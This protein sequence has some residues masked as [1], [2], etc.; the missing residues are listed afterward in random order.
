[1]IKRIIEVESLPTLPKRTRVA[2]YARVSSGKDTMLNSLST[3]INHYKKYITDNQSWIFAGVYAD[4][5][6]TGTK[7]DRDEFQ[8]LIA[9][10]SAGK[11]D[12]V[13][14]KSISRF[15]RNTVT[16]LKTI[17]ELK[18]LKV[19]VYFEEQN[20]HTLSSEGEMILTFLATFAQE[21]S[22]SVSENMKW[23]IKKDFEKGII[24]GG[25]SCLGY[26]LKNKKLHIVPSEAETVRF[27]YSMYLEG[28]S[29][30]LICKILDEKGISPYKAKRWNRTSLIK[31]LTNYN[32]TGDLV[33]QKTYRENH[34]NKTQ[35]I[36]IGNIE[37]YLVSN[38]HEPIISKDVFYEAQKLRKSKTKN[39]K[40]SNGDNDFKGYMKCAICGKAYTYKK[41]PYNVYWMCSTARTK[42]KKYC[43]AKQVPDSKV[44]EGIMSILNVNSFNKIEFI[45]K[46]KTIV[47]HEPNKLVFELLDGTS[48]KYLWEHDRRAN[49]W[50]EEMKEEARIK[51]LE[52][53]KGG[54]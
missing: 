35:K 8:Q 5:A 25:N 18:E 47:V 22:R 42:G 30:V 7:E 46:I 54:I 45:K 10:C 40:K 41:T 48:K 19:D 33:L 26:R 52:R 53:N 28:F 21:E 6:L 39:H 50:T 12:M 20:I 38:A 17:R 31:I 34:L 3:Q 49:S 4:E 51:A 1:M 9:D 13:I 37:Q 14:T 32:Y 29:D 44:K 27:I 23:R 15:A 11:I 2:A 36:N 43:K 24:W 16:L